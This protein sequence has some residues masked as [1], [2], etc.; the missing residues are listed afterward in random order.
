MFS[1]NPVAAAEDADAEAIQD[2][3]KEAEL[4]ISG[5]RNVVDETGALDMTCL[6]T[7]QTRID[8]TFTSD[9]KL[10]EQGYT[11]MQQICN[12]FDETTDV[13]L[14]NK[15]IAFSTKSMQ[16][17]GSTATLVC[18][19]TM[20]QKYI[21][22]EGAGAYRAVFGVS[23]TTETFYLVKDE[24]STWR[25]SSCSEMDYQFGSTTDMGLSTESLEQTFATREEACAYANSLTVEDICPLLTAK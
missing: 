20:P 4:L 5:P 25:V 6:Q 13:V 12:S 17:D 10:I 15:I 14:E 22:Y 8:Q 7:Y 19:I 11:A 1:L 23:T 16:I 2:V 24:G 3:A 18:D 21:P 9:F